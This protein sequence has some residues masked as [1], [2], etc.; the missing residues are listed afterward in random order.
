LYLVFDDLGRLELF[1]R[2][3]LHWNWS[4]IFL[5]IRLGFEETTDVLSLVMSRVHAICTLAH[6]A[7][8]ADGVLARF[9]HCEV[10]LSTLRC[11]EGSH[12]AHPTRKEG[13]CSTLTA[14]YL[15]KLSESLPCQLRL[16]IY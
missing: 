5:K 12:C 16:L 2:T 8:L 9:L 6:L 10:S 11:L 3:P 13:S 15:R 14:G 1:S 4:E 7:H